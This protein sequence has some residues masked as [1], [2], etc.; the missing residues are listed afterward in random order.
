MLLYKKGAS[1][2]PRTK[3]KRRLI[4]A[5]NTDLLPPK[6]LGTRAAAVARAFSCAA[7]RGVHLVVALSLELVVQDAGWLSLVQMSFI[8]GGGHIMRTSYPN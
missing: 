4:C 3:E 7:G 1:K 5:K 6:L 2:K 8:E